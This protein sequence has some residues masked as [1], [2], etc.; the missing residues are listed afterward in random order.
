MAA[1][2]ARRIL[3][4]IPVIWAVSLL[5]FLMIH[6]LPGDPVMV[7]LSAGNPTPEQ[8]AAV[9]GQLRLDEPLPLQ[10]LHYI[11][12]V[13]Q[14]DLG[15]SVFTK[16]AVSAEIADQLPRTIELAVSALLIS[17]TLGLVLGTVAAVRQH[18]WV[19]TLASAVALVGVSMPSFWLGLLLI[20]F[21]SLQLGWLPAT[22]QGGLNRLILPAL[23]LGLSF[24]A[25]T[26]RLVRS[27]LI[28]ILQQE[29]VLTA[30]AK[31]L[32]ERVLLL[33]HALRNA[34]IPVVTILG[35]QFGNLLAGTIVVETVFSRQGIGRL[36]VQ[37]ILD[38]DLPVVQG[39]VLIQA[40]GYILA[41]LA[42]DLSYFVLDPRIRHRY[43]GEGR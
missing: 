28:E 12:R 32:V 6:L 15:Q 42:V 20:F 25:I 24:S 22:G 1:F 16:R 7:M 10:Y 27:S 17:T 34:L 35:V 30:R 29:Y 31:G 41:N 11:S 14:G 33:R 37:A 36:A 21:F 26:T 18:T 9:R 23:T 4:A 40:T 2:A 5:V 19:D 38:K 39:V 13:V 43:E 3:V 8:I